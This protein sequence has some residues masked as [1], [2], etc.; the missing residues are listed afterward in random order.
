VFLI[1]E[2]TQPGEAHAIAERLRREVAAIPRGATASV[3]VAS[4]TREGAAD[5]DAR[6]VIEHLGDAAD[7]AMYE[8]KRAGGNQTRHAESDWIHST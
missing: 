5:V 4:I 3:G 7:T 6:T 8:A 2:T 1:A